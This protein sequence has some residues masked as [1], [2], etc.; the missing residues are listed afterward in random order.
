MIRFLDGT[1]SYMTID[2]TGADSTNQAQALQPGDVESLL[3]YEF[4]VVTLEDVRIPVG[5]RAVVVQIL[6]P[7][8]QTT[9]CFD[10]FALRLGKSGDMCGS[11]SFWVL[12]PAGGWYD[13]GMTTTRFIFVN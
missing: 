7:V 10:Y 13:S 12:Q 8:A 11:P 4:D 3:Y 1:G 5:A 2:T 6:V 9:F